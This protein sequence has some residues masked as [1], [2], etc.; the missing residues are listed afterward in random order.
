MLQIAL[1]WF[2]IDAFTHLSLELSYV[3]LALGPTAARSDSP[4]AYVWRE[5]GRADK[6]LV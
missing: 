2:I 1:A 4:F 3:L 6:R 5:Y